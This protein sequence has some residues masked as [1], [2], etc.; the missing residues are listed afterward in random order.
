MTK[1]QM[2]STRMATKIEN[3]LWVLIDN[4]YHGILERRLRNNEA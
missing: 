3:V 2:I 1:L 4:E